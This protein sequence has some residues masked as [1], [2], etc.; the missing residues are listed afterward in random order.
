MTD[1]NQ[2]N[3]QTQEFENTNGFNPKLLKLEYGRLCKRFDKLMERYKTIQDEYEQ[4][5][6]QCYNLQSELVSLKSAE[7]VL[8]KKVNDQVDKDLDD[9]WWDSVD[10]NKVELDAYYNRIKE[11]NQKN[12]ELVHQNKELTKN[13]DDS[14]RQL[15]YVNFKNNLLE[16]K[17]SFRD[18]TLKMIKQCIEGETCVKHNNY[19]PEKS[20]TERCMEFAKKR[21]EE[22]KENKN[23]LAK[24]NNETD[25]HINENTKGTDVNKIEKII[26]PSYSALDQYECEKDSKMYQETAIHKEEGE[27]SEDEE[28]VYNISSNHSKEVNNTENTCNLQNESSVSDYSSSESSESEEESQEESEEEDES[29]DNFKKPTND[30]NFVNYD[31]GQNNEYPITDCGNNLDNSYYSSLY[32]KSFKNVFPK[33]NEHIFRNCCLQILYGKIPS[34]GCWTQLNNFDITYW[35]SFDENQCYQI[36]SSLWNNYAKE[37]SDL[38]DL[39]TNI[40]NNT[41]QEYR[42]QNIAYN[43]ML[44]QI[45]SWLFN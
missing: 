27:I 6:N 10:L 22:R 21:S 35:D 25:I 30:S 36:V 45:V 9:P 32:T 39:I 34:Y 43:H 4:K 20:L 26:L 33:N 42:N 28:I 17:V 24:K 38:S 2:N 23:E 11:L 40:Q 7:F 31:Y 8:D 14:K 29:K 16:K 1:M 44:K 15:K 13:L 18:G 19:V 3:S 5:T 37:Y 12:L 41:P